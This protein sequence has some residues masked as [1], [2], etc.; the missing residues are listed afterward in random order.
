MTLMKYLS[1]YSGKD[2]PEVWL[3]SYQAAARSEGWSDDQ[4]LQCIRLKLKK[5]AKEWYNNL[6]LKEKP[7]LWDELVTLFLEEFGD[8]DVQTSLARCY[9]IMQ[10]KNESLKKYLHRYQKYLKKHDSA[11]KRDVAKNTL[12]MLL[13]HCL[14]QV[15]KPRM[16]LLIEKVRNY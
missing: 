15:L 14:I 4:I 10:K 9:R 5:R 7:K 2:D 13:N 11:V 12:N 16:N 6:S 8:E 3:D 1:P